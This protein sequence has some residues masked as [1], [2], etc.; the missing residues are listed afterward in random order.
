MR[1]HLPFLEARAGVPAFGSP[2]VYS[3]P[4]WLAWVQ[5]RQQA[6]WWP[7]AALCSGNGC[8]HPYFTAGKVRYRG[9]HS[10]VQGARLALV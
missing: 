8:H 6:W 7:A 9:L 10:L 4:A 1:F 3:S 2:F 5:T